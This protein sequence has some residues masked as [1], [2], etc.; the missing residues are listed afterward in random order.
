MKLKISQTQFASI[1]E[2]ASHAIPSK[3][4]QPILSSFVLHGNSETQKL[5]VTAFNLNLGIRAQCDCTVDRK[6]VV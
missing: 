5:T 1:L 4:I 2:I 6:S 3:P